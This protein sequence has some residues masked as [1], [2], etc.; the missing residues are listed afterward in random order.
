MMSAQSKQEPFT[1]L[2]EVEM[3][4]FWNLLAVEKERPRS[5]EIV[6]GCE[7]SAKAWADFLRRPIMNR[8][9]GLECRSD[10]VLLAEPRSGYGTDR[11]DAEKP[12]G[13]PQCVAPGC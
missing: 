4:P 7:L 8:G 2:L 9:A 12:I 3:D 11:S 13:E 10:F 6:L 5:W 1:T